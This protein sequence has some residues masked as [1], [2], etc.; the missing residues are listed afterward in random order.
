MRAVLTFGFVVLIAATAYL[1]SYLALVQR[2][3]G[4][5]NCG[6]IGRY[7]TYR[8]SGPWP[9]GL[10]GKIYEP[11]HQLDRRFFRRTVWMEKQDLV[12]LIAT[13]LAQSGPPAA[14]N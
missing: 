12:A 3:W 11:A 10:A 9:C 14:T 5:A 13:E 8:F 7:P 4:D 6:W 1:G 2:G